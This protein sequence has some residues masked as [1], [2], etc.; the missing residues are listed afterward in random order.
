MIISP[1]LKK[2]FKFIWKPFQWYFDL[3]RKYNPFLWCFQK[4]RAKIVEKDDV[5]YKLAEPY[6]DDIEHKLAKHK[7]WEHRKLDTDDTAPDFLCLSKIDYYDLIQLMLTV[8]TLADDFY[9]S[10]KGYLEE[11]AMLLSFIITSLENFHFTDPEREHEK[12]KSLKK[13][14]DK[15]VEH[16]PNE[17]SLYVK[18]ERDK[19]IAKEKSFGNG[20]VWGYVKGFIAAYEIPYQTKT[21]VQLWLDLA[22]LKAKLETVNVP[23][24]IM[25]RGQF[26]VELEILMGDLDD[27]INQVKQV[28][29][30]NIH[31]I[32]SLKQQIDALNKLLEKR[33]K[34]LYALQDENHASCKLLNSALVQKDLEIGSLKTIINEKDITNNK[35]LAEKDIYYQKKL[36]I[37]ENDQ[38]DSLKKFTE[39]LE[40]MRKDKERLTEVNNKILQQQSTPL[41]KQI[42]LLT[43]KNEELQEQLKREDRQK[44]LL[45]VEI[46]HLE[47]RLGEKNTSEIKLRQLEIKIFTML[48]HL[49]MLENPNM[50]LLGPK[51]Y[52]EILGTIN[53]EYTEMK[54]SFANKDIPETIKISLIRISNRL[55]RALQVRFDNA[56]TSDINTEIITTDASVKVI[57]GDPDIFSTI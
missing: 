22:N 2:T 51:P 48:G 28:D 32:T 11:H 3:C 44:K 52:F 54:D 26:F 5:E 6:T 12:L 30:K 40:E 45:R 55:D 9:P 21:D 35:A 8:L 41:R 13:I 29:D 16:F 20:Y 1:K 19:E 50:K 47:K 33:N 4:L 49:D 57:A 15:F 42:S 24:S 56:T 34:E 43:K 17:N 31:E 53:E 14:R 39:K 36:E 38:R 27:I 25:K 23:K 10:K 18:I 37:L 7:H 46:K